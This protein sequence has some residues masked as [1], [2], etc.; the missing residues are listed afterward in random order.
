MKSA[1]LVVVA[2]FV[3]LI[4]GG[5]ILILNP[6]ASPIPT[7]EAQST[8][9]TWPQLQN[10]PQHTGYTAEGPTTTAS[11]AWAF[12][13]AQNNLGTQRGPERLF[14]QVQPIIANSRVYLGTSNGTFYA[15]NATSGSISWTYP[16][17][18]KVGSI[19]STAAYSAS[20]NRVYFASMD[21]KIYGLNATT[22]ALEKTFDS[23]SRAGFS[24]SLIINGSTIYAINRSGKVYSLTL[25]L[26]QNWQRS[27]NVPV[28]M[29][30][31]FDNDKLF[32]GAMDMKVYALNASNG[33]TLWSTQVNG[34]AFKDYWPVAYNQKVYIRS[35]KVEEVNYDEPIGLT[36]VSGTL[37]QSELDKQ[38]NTVIP[39]LQ[40]NPK[41]RDLFI[42][43]Q[44]T[45][46]LTLAPHYPANTMNGAACPP[47]VDKN[48]YLIMP[49]NW[50][51]EWGSGWG[52]YNPATNRI[53][54][55]LWDGSDPTG[56]GD[57]S[58]CVSVA[59]NIVYIF[60]TEEQ[61][62]SFT[63]L[64]NLATKRA[65]G[66]G[67]YNAEWFFWN[68]TQGGGTT[69]ASIANGYVYHTTQ[70]T[71]NARKVN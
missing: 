27:L 26:T 67:N 16:S 44:T 49:V 40:N 62:A 58:T 71:L 65:V 53:V 11:K 14:P 70:N 12:G 20:N 36:R 25:D 59:D 63:G 54:E 13:F 34:Q 33:N 21:G 55:I 52:R 1:Y 15:F 35:Q 57:E 37:P 29:S 22:G 19:I 45:G 47:S 2:V 56:S 18:S 39:H 38:A 4:S 50:S 31:A 41:D 24:A 64:Y 3:A 61:N 68:N 46:A 51:N 60:H 17:N 42:L 43:D 8:T 23:Q 10:N 32:F 48:G 9:Y 28:F 7:V 6:Q 69:P 5:L 30:M 66:I